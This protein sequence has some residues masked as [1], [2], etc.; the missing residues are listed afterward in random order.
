MG[1]APTYSQTGA[2]ASVVA[3]SSI[4]V[5][6]PATVADN[7]LAL[8]VVSLAVA[9]GPQCTITWPSGWTQIGQLQQGTEHTGG[10]AWKRLTVADG[11]TSPTVTF[12]NSQ[13]G[14]VR[15][16]TYLGV[17][18]SI[19]P[20]FY[21]VQDNQG[22]SAS[23]AFDAYAFIGNCRGVHIGTYARN[24]NPSPSTN[25][26][27]QI[28]AGANGA[29]ITIEDRDLTGL[30]SPEAAVS[31]A[32]TSDD[33]C[34]WSFALIPDED[35]DVRASGLATGEVLYASTTANPD[36]RGSGLATGE[37]LSASVVAPSD[38]RASGSA[39]GEVAEAT[40]VYTPGRLSRTAR[41]PDRVARGDGFDRSTPRL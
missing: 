12:S 16:G 23:Q 11:G 14:V 2:A 38:A 25:Y 3:V 27:E 7:E 39:T 41:P 19:S 31:R 26:T 20:P 40:V 18:P 5:P 28:D 21:L 6:L 35:M 34:T 22:T 10:C 32:V 24:V 13:T 9:G 15:V 33:W 1:V 29:R 8:M 30:S 36:A 4:N 37:I 17:T